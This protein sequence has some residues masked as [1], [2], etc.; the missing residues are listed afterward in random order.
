MALPPVVIES[1]ATQSSFQAM[2]KRKWDQTG[3]SAED[4]PSKVT[5]VEDGKSA[6]EAAAAAVS[7]VFVR[8]ACRLT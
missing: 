5:K 7:T 8:V 1:T 4:T 6:S 3:D 2:S